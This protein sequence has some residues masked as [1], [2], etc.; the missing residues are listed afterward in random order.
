MTKPVGYFGLFLVGLAFAAGW[1]PCIGPVLG[2]VLA[3]V[4]PNPTLGT[5]Y[6]V[7]YAIGFCLPFLVL[8]V[9]LTSVRALLKYT[10]RIA[11]VGGWLLML[12][13]LLLISD[14]MT[15]ISVW[16][17]ERNGMHGLLVQLR[18][19]G[20]RYGVQYA[21]HARFPNFSP[22][23][24]TKSTDR[25]HGLGFQGPREFVHRSVCATI[26]HW[27]HETHQLASNVSRASVT[28]ARFTCGLIPLPRYA[29]SRYVPHSTATSSPDKYSGGT[30]FRITKPATARR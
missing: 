20:R 12:M 15:W 6:M 25:V 21:I 1:T 30:L 13:G 27:N 29:G 24:G 8:A 18:H 14:K 2:S 4:M 28:I 26:G 10:H 7:A 11:Q 19:Y 3:L 23:V 22:Q 17:P 16:L 9:T 5:A